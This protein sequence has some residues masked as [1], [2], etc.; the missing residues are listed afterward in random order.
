MDKISKQDQ[1]SPIEVC[2]DILQSNV[3]KYDNSF[4][5]ACFCSFSVLYF[6]N[7]HMNY[8]ELLIR[9]TNDI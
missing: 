4:T 9:F 7:N 8:Y 3:S 5:M 6:I 2:L 1:K